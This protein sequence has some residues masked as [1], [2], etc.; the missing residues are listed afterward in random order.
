MIVRITIECKNPTY[1]VDM[2]RRATQQ[3]EPYA[4]AKYTVEFLD[5]AEKDED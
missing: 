1:V 2:M 4:G 3:V 5:E